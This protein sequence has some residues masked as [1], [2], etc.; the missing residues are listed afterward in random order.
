MLSTANTGQ[1]QERNLA[2]GIA[3]QTGLVIVSDDNFPSDGFTLRW[4]TGGA[5]LDEYYVTLGTT[6]GGSDIYQSR[7]F[8]A[9][10]PETTNDYTGTWTAGGLGVEQGWLRLYYRHA[11]GDFRHVDQLV[12]FDYTDPASTQWDDALRWDDTQRWTE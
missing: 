10:Y 3:P 11:D 6:V 1:S 12:T 4:D 9:S 7:R 5:V 8:L 2:G